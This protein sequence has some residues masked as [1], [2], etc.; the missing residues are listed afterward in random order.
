LD[1]A[2]RSL[3]PEARRLFRRIGSLRLS[4]VCDWTAAALA[5]TAQGAADLLETLADAYL[6][7][8]REAARFHCHDII[9]A[10]ARERAD[11]EE[12]KE[13]QWASVERVMG[14]LLAQTD[15]AYA[16]IHGRPPPY[17]TAA[18]R[19]VEPQMSVRSG[20]EWLASNLCIINQAVRRCAEYGLDTHCWEL[21]IAP[22]PLFESGGY[23]DE[24]LD[25]HEVALEAVHRSGDLR[26]QAMLWYSLGHRAAL[27]AEHEEA[28][29]LL[30]RGQVLFERI[31]DVYG[32]G[33]VARDLGLIAHRGEELHHA[34]DA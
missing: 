13:Q 27:R 32:Q 31:E 16:T 20:R 8:P 17:A 18:R 7:Q 30:E 24:W 34:R 5:S 22:L 9:L 14:A 33:L 11:S 19:P 10:Y 1:V 6:L 28:M 25:G 29:T 23:N 21:A 4:D 3:P 15:A 2:Y 12:P 26:G